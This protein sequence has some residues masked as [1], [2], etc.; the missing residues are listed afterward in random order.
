MRLL[1]LF[2]CI[3]ILCSCKNVNKD[4]THVLIVSPYGDIEIELYD[5]KAPKTV[6]A[7]LSYIDKG[8]YK[9][10]HFYRVLKNE[11]LTAADNYGVIQAGT[12][13]QPTNVPP[14]VHE[15]TKQT[16]LSHVSGI[17]SMASSGA[18]TATT[19]FF[20]CIGQQKMYD[21][22]GGGTKDNEGFAAFGK[23]VEGMDAVRKIQDQK[24]TGDK[25]DKMILINT[26]KKM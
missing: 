12:W 17:I 1:I 19:E 4:N 20:I 10:S 16:G 25:F 14:L 23:V 3:A 18:G 5:K 2:F 13:P 21:A 7:F 6:A 15:S 9:N 24:N 22:G 8:I 26:I 11:D